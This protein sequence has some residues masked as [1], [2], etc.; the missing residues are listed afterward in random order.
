MARKKMALANLDFARITPEKE[1][2]LTAVIIQASLAAGMSSH[3]LY[4]EPGAQPRA[5]TAP[6]RRRKIGRNERCP[7]GSGRKYKMCCALRAIG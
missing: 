7:C 4:G 1:A 5:M 3:V 6:S 2:E